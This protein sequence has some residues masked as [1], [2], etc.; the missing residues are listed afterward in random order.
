MKTIDV[1]HD[2]IAIVNFA[3]LQWLQNV[4]KAPLLIYSVGD[5]WLV[6]LQNRSTE[7]VHQSIG[8]T[9]GT[10][11]ENVNFLHVVLTPV[12]VSKTRDSCHLTT[13][14][15]HNCPLVQNFMAFTLES[16]RQE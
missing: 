8:N 14:P 6:K 10:T 13:L 2:L 4:K 12:V 3:Q 16:G 9:R 15:R 11:F 5:F 7:R 1:R